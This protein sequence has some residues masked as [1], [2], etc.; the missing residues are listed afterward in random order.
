MTPPVPS[1][2]R[3][4]ARGPGGATLPAPALAATAQIG[5]RDGDAPRAS[6]CR[7]W[8]VAA[9]R[10][11]RSGD[12]GRI[13]EA[14]E[15]PIAAPASSPVGASSRC[16]PPVSVMIG[17]ATA[18]QKNEKRPIKSHF[19]AHVLYSDK[20]R[21]AARHH[22]RRQTQCPRRGRSQG[23]RSVPTRIAPSK[24]PD[25]SALTTRQSRR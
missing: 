19:P 13:V 12:N 23:G 3:P 5:A 2:T 1:R 21:R 6:L 11:G 9:S 18:H 4:R 17:V 14:I 24:G 15:Q 25:R 22:S 10:A 7:D 20:S 16:K 8:A